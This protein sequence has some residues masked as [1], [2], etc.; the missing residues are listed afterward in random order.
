MVAP[1]GYV[2]CCQSP[3]RAVAVAGG[4]PGGVLN[5][6]QVPGLIVSVDGG[7]GGA[8]RL[9]TRALPC[10]IVAVSDSLGVR[11]S[12]EGQLVVVVVDVGGHSA[13]VTGGVGGDVS[14]C[15]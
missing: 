1:F 10:Q 5:R 9:Q 4:L 14:S 8:G 13:G 15:F 7:V 2:V 6:E 3:S 12:F 11:Q